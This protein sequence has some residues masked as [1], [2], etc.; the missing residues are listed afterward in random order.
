MNGGEQLFSWAIEP[1]AFNGSL[2]L[3]RDRSVGIKA[4][5]VVEPNKVYQF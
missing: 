4:A 5:K 3:N 2:L 1:N